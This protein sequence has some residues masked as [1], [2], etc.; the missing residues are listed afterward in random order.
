MGVKE[1]GTRIGKKKRKRRR[2]VRV[3]ECGTR[4]EKKK[5]GVGGGEG[6]GNEMLVAEKSKDGGSVR[7]FFFWQYTWE[8][9]L[10]PI[11]KCHYK[12]EKCC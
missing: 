2:E 1:C 8:S 4:S 7:V 12:L 9:S 10:I 11:V 6:V 3:K 5:V